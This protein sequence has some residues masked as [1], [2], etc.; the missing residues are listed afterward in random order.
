MAF[1]DDYLQHHGWSARIDSLLALVGVLLLAGAVPLTF[2]FTRRQYRRFGVTCTNCGRPLV[3]RSGEEA[4][5]TGR[6]RYCGEKIISDSD[7]AQR[8]S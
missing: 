2:W 3:G 4:V 5:A 7:V 6:C 1:V 8:T